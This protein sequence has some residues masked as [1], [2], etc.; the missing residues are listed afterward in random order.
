MNPSYGLAIRFVSTCCLLAAVSLS[1]NAEPGPEEALGGL[2]TFTVDTELGGISG[3]G[4]WITLVCG[5]DAAV[6]G[7]RLIPAHGTET[8]DLPLG[9]G[10]STHCSIQVREPGALLIRY[11]GDGG[12]Q[13]DI[14]ED[15]CR[16]GD[17]RAG[18]ANFCQIRSEV[19]ET[20][21]TVYKKWIGT[22]RAEDDVTVTLSCSDGYRTESG[23]L[24]A[25]RPVSW[26]LSVNDP[27][28]VSCS[29]LEQAREEFIPDV[30]D[31]REL[32]VL[33]GAEEECTVVNTKVVK[34][35]E[36][37]NRY[38]LF[39]MIF[40]FLVAGMIASRRFMS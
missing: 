21:I 40:V 37:L 17:V 35:I 33:P 4:L 6:R 29:V 25:G 8:F 3:Q 1:A 22:T 15:G 11:R 18:H 32:L 9:E 31:C 10:E 34:M 16:F 28:G 39:I 23:E 20:S 36:M 38:G 19:R 26:N 12:S 30:E 5:D 2:A 14:S 27:D 24:N 13:A 7:S